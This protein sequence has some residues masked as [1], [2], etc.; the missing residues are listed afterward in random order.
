[1][2]ILTLRSPTSAPREYILKAG[3]ITLGRK[4]DSGIVIADE[5]ASRLHAEVDYNPEINT[6]VIRDLGSRNGTFVNRE[7]ITRPHIL[8]PEDQI[9][10]GQ[11][12]VSAAFRDDTL[13]SNFTTAFSGTHPL[14]RELVLEAADRHA[15]LLYEVASRFNTTLDLEAALREISKLMRA[16]MGAEKCEVV[17]AEQFSNLAEWGFPTS[18]ARQAIEQRSVVVIPDMSSQVEHACGNSA[19]LLHV[20]S[21]LCAPV[22]AGEEI[23][24]LIYVYK[25]DPASQPFNKHDVQ[26]AVAISHQAAL[27]IQRTRLLAERDRAAAALR[28]SE[29]RY[30]SLFEEAPVMYVITENR[31]GVPYIIE[32]N[33]AF[34]ET[35]GYQRQDVI[36]KPLSH[37][38]T[39]TS[40]LQMAHGGY[41]AAL[42]GPVAPKECRLVARDG[43]I[44]QTLLR[45]SLETDVHGNAIGTRAMYVNIT[46]SKIAEAEQRAGLLLNELTRSAA[47]GLDLRS[48]AQR[49]ADQLGE[50]FNADGCYV[51]LWNEANQRAIPLATCGELRDIYPAINVPPGER[52]MTESVLYAG[53]TLAAEDVFNTPHMSPV[54]AARFPARSILGLPLLAG[55]QKLGAVLI[56]F[57]KS[58]RFT[59]DEIARAERAAGPIALV[60]A[61]ARLF[62]ELR[63]AHAELAEAYNATLEGWV[64]ALDLRD[65]EIEGHSR[66]VT[67]MTTRLVQAMGLSDSELVHARRGALLHDIG[68]MGIPDAIL[69]KPSKL[70]DDEWVIMKR[71]PQD[72]YEMLSPIAYLRPAL[73]IPYCHHEKWDGTGYPRGLKGEQI[74]LAARFFAVVDVWDALRSDRPYRSAWPEEKVREYIRSL[75]GTH[76]DPQVTEVFLRMTHESEL[77]F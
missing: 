73:D 77:P 28:K 58:H 2:W 33:R 15:F 13:S 8:Q 42:R 34:L 14:T 61:K 75:A 35:L 22:I 4:S 21:A 46:D 45:A 3:K 59:P 38:Y 25:T 5:S 41:T 60:V 40:Q 64:R 76:F 18:I 24:A 56:A 69:R 26:L 52:T 70:T 71:H 1:M 9:R 37:F 63:E 6:L 51:T 7:R 62:D 31:G 16:A 30:R 53:R 55:D 49:L 48:A 65:K 50:L 68:K 23:V 17:L 67:E 10:I 39:Q 12:V 74:P 19:L 20:R 72:A 44:V 43:Q 11:Y 54:L 36:E 32:C 29:S 66:R 57:N 47:S 27:T